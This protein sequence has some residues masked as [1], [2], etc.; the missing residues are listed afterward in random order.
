MAFPGPRADLIR[1]VFLSQ[2]VM[3]S[4]KQSTSQRFFSRKSEIRCQLPALL[5]SAIITRINPALDA[6][7]GQGCSFIC[8]VSLPS[9]AWQRTQEVWRLPEIFWGG[10]KLMFFLVGF[11]FFKNTVSVQLLVL[12]CFVLRFCSIF[13]LCHCSSLSHSR[14]LAYNT[15]HRLRKMFDIHHTYSFYTAH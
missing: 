7:T 15:L 8:S 10:Q 14:I 3:E 5:D 1:N 11:G 9:G 13:I 12:L 6:N 2:E 4:W